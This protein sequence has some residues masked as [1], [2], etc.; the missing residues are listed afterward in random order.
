[1]FAERHL[2]EAIFECDNLEGKNFFE[3]LTDY[4]KFVIRKNYGNNFYDYKKVDCRIREMVFTI[5]LRYLRND[6]NSCY[7]K[8]DDESKIGL[9]FNNRIIDIL[10]NSK[11]LLGRLSTILLPSTKKGDEPV[12]CI[13]L[14]V[15]LSKRRQNFDDFLWKQ[16]FN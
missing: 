16:L 15:K 3:L 10:N 12:A 13:L 9:D 1:M 5:D 6:S 14:E 2:T 7:N 4:S 8:K 11:T